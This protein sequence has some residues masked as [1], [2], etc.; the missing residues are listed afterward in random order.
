[1]VE[2]AGEL[3][4]SLGLSNFAAS[5]GIGISGVDTRT[6]LRVGLIFGVFEAVCPSPGWSWA[7][8]WPARSAPTRTTS[9]GTC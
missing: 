9:V 3:V 6:R 4:I 8:P 7:A 2:V 1:V 5:I